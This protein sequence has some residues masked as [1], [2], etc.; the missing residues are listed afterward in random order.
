MPRAREDP[1]RQAPPSRGRRP[2][3]GA[4]EAARSAGEARA[5]WTLAPRPRPLRNSTAA[6]ARR[7]HRFSWINSV[8]P[9]R[10]RCCT[11][12]P[13]FYD[14]IPKPKTTFCFRIFRPD[15]Y[16]RKSTCYSVSSSHTSALTQVPTPEESIPT[17]RPH[18][19][20]AAFVA[21]GSSRTPPPCFLG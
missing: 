4:R 3:A 18:P 20:L 16:L 19:K 7:C 21:A 13:V 10:R 2:Y 8:G 9:L 14:Y 17:F 1:R 5:H 15:R 6:W 11:Q 12:N